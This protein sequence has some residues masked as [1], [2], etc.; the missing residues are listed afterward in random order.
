MARFPSG[1]TASARSD[2]FELFAAAFAG[3]NLHATQLG[4]GHFEGAVTLASSADMQFCRADWNTPLLAQYDPP[5]GTALVGFSIGAPNPSRLKGHE[6]DPHTAIALCLPGD[7]GHLVTLGATEVVAVSID[8][9]LLSR[10][11]EARF[12]TDLASLQRHW[13]VQTPPGTPDCHARGRAVVALQSVLL[14]GAARSEEA[15]RRL[16]EC[17]LQLMLEDLD[18]GVLVQRVSPA[19]RYR[20]LRNADELL[21]SRLDDPPS[22]RELCELVHASER[23]LHHAFQESFGMGPKSYLRAMRLGAARTRLMRGEGPVTEI[24]TSLGFFHLGRFAVE[25]H[26]MFEETPSETLRNARSTATAA[27]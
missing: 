6:V 26:Q 23:T 15:Q 2:E 1:F 12:G 11:L 19:M 3:W 8:E 17:A 5:R 21:R 25:Y 22:L 20:I 13:A 24:A 4:R 27:S 10:H 16:E 18:I 7:Q 14:N 9:A